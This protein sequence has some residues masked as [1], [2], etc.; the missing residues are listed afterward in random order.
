METKSVMAMATKR[1]MVSDSNN[2]DHNNN[3]DR[4]NN[5]YQDNNGNKDDNG[6][7][8][9][10][11][12]NKGNDNNSNKGNSD[13]DE[14]KDSAAVA[15]G[16]FVGGGEAA[17]VVS[18]VASFGRRWMVVVVGL[19]VADSGRG[20]CGGIGGVAVGGAAAA[21]CRPSRVFGSHVIY[22]LAGQL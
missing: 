6:N 13:N 4:D 7:D 14:D 15:V 22:L 1:A 3:N 2:N 17:I 11:N 19:A 8:Y 10:N 21:C 5:G 9:T 12:D 16:G 20:T 18:V